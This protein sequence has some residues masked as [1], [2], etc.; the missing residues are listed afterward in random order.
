MIVILKKVQRG[1]KDQERRKK[2]KMKKEIKQKKMRVQ[3]LT[4]QKLILLP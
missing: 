4:I 3:L 1:Q 2:M